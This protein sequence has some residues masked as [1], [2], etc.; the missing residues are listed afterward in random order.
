MIQWFYL[1]QSV[2]GSTWVK[3]FQP[4]PWIQ[5]CCVLSRCQNQCKLGELWCVF[6]SNLSTLYRC[7]LHCCVPYTFDFH[8][9]S[10]FI[11]FARIFHQQLFCAMCGRI[12]ETEQRKL[13]GKLWN[14]SSWRY[15]S[16][17]FLPLLILHTGVTRSL[18]S[19]SGWLR[20]QVRLQSKQVAGSF[21]GP[22]QSD[23]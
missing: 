21:Q 2:S 9:T 7:R 8:P 18:E 4:S 11:Y 1:P 12:G 23:Q 20:V 13:P 19:I 10:R 5:M 22:E 14:V 3:I 17:N 6:G 15:P 16:I